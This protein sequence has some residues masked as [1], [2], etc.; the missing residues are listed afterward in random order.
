MFVRSTLS[1][2]KFSVAILC[3]SELKLFGFGSRADRM[4]KNTHW[5]NVPAIRVNTSKS[6]YTFTSVK[7]RRQPLVLAQIWV[8]LAKHEQIQ[9]VLAEGVPL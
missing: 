9:K 3:A 1:L 8:I 4:T 6:M 5:Y 7:Q 2:H